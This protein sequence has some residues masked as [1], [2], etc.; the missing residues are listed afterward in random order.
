M[1]SSSSISSFELE[2]H[3][4]SREITPVGEDLSSSCTELLFGENDR[5]EGQNL[6]FPLSII[7]TTIS[8]PM[9]SLSVRASEEAPRL[10]I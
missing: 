2:D 7:V 8:A 10:V 9:A 5:N 1:A 3:L 6:F 4:V